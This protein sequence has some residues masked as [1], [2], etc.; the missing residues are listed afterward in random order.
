M[1]ADATVAP[2]AS[3]VP[4]WRLHRGCVL[5]LDPECR[6]L[7]DVPTL[8]GTAAIGT[9]AGQPPLVTVHT[10]EN[11]RLCTGS[12]CRVCWGA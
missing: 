10:A 6:M 2:T 5:H 4:V 12:I 7:P 8:I 9:H 1:L 11:V 3:V